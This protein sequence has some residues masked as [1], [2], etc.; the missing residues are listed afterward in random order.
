MD[1]LTCHFYIP[2]KMRYSAEFKFEKKGST[3]LGATF[4]AFLMIAVAIAILVFL[5]KI[6]ELLNDF[7]GS[8]QSTRS[9]IL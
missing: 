6:L 2:E 3:W 8:F 9:N 1:T 4:F 5:P 7:V